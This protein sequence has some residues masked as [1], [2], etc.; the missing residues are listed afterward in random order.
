MTLVATKN[1]EIVKESM[2]R[3]LRKPDFMDKFY[4]EF[5]KSAEVQ[6]KFKNT[7]MTMQKVILKSS[8]H[9]MLATA[10]GTP[11]AAM[12][13]LALSHDRGHKAIPAHLYKVWLE[14]MLYAVKV[15]DPEYTPELD[16]VWREVMLPGVEFMSGKY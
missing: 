14:A 7:N 5:L 15:T 13:K 4:D 2:Q 3:C 11:G 6:E 10:K 9:L 8:L 1:I 16:G 12:D